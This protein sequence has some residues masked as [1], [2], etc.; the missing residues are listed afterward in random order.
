M[1]VSARTSVTSAG[2]PAGE[3]QAQGSRV[4]YF[5]WA[6][7]FGALGIVV[8]H[9]FIAICNETPSPGV[10]MGRWLVY[11]E[12]GMVLSR[13][14]VPVFLMVSGALLLDPAKELG[15]PKLRRY[16][17]RMLF[18]ICTFG[19]AFALM[20]E[21]VD[22]G[23]GWG[24]VLVSLRDLVFEQSWD[25]LWY[26]YAMVGIYALTPLLRAFVARASR[27]EYRWTLAWLLAFC[28]AVPTLN[29]LLGWSLTAFCLTIPCYFTYYLMGHYVHTYLRFDWRW[30]VA[31]LACVAA[32][33]WLVAW[34][35]P[36]GD[37]EAGL[38]YAPGSPLLCVYAVAIF[39]GLRRLLDAV[40][41]RS[42]PAA[43]VLARY[44]FGVYLIHPLFGHLALMLTN[45]LDYPPVL[46][47][48]AV[49]AMATVGSVALTWLL[50][51]LPGF[52]RA[53]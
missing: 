22:Q 49:I 12:L 32:M 14:C 6:R 29:S 23:P 39:L 43:A 13:W 2:G 52:R 5:E 35:T 41:I 42:V 45:P 26:V 46:Y 19:L 27:G 33:G 34:G 16:V 30:A 11:R 24:M 36:R 20:Q 28:F 8:L 15:L 25:H 31:G 40:P 18:I 48:V 21:Y 7:A 1:G 53:L 9:V 4:Q 50:K 3:V 51:R 37:V 38:F 44:S 47:E 17:G 10:S